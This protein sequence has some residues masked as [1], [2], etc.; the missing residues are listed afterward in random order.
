M[1]DIQIW[2]YIILIIFAG[3]GLGAVI[4]IIATWWRKNK[5]YNEGGYCG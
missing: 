4:Y 3:I 5:K 2:I 1:I